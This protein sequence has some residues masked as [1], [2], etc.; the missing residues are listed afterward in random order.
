MKTSF[1]DN[2]PVHIGNNVRR[3]REISGKKQYE[4][5][6]EC[7]LTPKQMSRLESSESIDDDQLEMIAKKLDVTSEF[8]KN[9]KEEHAINIIQHDITVQDNATNN[10]YQNVNHPVNAFIEF[11]EKFI[12]K[13]QKIT[14]SLEEISKS[15]LS[16]DE[17]IK[18]MKQENE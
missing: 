7:D 16:L 9:F 12:Q 3:I 6:E 13:D 4:L 11:F 17:E 15:I 14:Q 18:K 2:E 5:A 10:G 1:K 8:I